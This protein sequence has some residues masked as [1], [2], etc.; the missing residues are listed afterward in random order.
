LILRGVSA[1]QL[2]SYPEKVATDLACCGNCRYLRGQ[3]CLNPESPL[4]GFKV[5]ATGVC[6]SF[7][8]I[9]Q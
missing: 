9:L 7:D 5:T 3:R 2:M 4:H 1:R 8:P 6:R